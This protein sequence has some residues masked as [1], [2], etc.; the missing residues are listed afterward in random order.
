M[1][2]TEFVVS[3]L[4]ITPFNLFRIFV[5]VVIIKFTTVTFLSSDSDSS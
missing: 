1:E 5:I 2:F 4:I 3:L